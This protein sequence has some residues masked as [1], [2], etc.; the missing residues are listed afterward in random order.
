MYPASAP[1]AAPEPIPHRRLALDIL[2]SMRRGNP[3]ICGGDSAFLIWLDGVPNVVHL[4]AYL[5]RNR[6]VEPI[7]EEGTEARHFILTESG[8]D[9]HDRGERWWR[10]LDWKSRL[11][12]MLFG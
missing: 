4:F 7:G 12:A 2:R 6:Y 5:L 1:N 9:L 3:I 10:S 8:R 11:Q